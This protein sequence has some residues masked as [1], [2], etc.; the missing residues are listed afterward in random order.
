MSA[1]QGQTPPGVNQGP[2]VTGQQGGLPFG[3]PSGNNSGSLAMTRF[4]KMEFPKFNGS[5]LR[6]WLCKVE[7]YFS[8]DEVPH[9]QKVKI[10]SIHFDDIAV[11]WHLAYFEK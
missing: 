3:S 2:T 8:M 10:A 11:E 6:T 9:I 7:Q 4:T 5:N 1:P